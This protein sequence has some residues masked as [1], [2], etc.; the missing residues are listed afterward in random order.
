MGE[1]FLSRM[2]SVVGDIEAVLAL[3]PKVKEH[4]AYVPTRTTKKAR[5]YWKRNENIHGCSK[6]RNFDDIK[7]TSLSERGA[8]RESNRC[9]K[10]VDA[11]CQ[12]SCPTQLDVKSFIGCISNRNFYG[13]AKYIFSD[14]PLGLTCGMVCPTS[15]LCV[16]GCNLYDAEEG[17][18]NIGGLQQFATE[19]FKRMN[20]P[21]IRDP[22][23]PPLSELPD[24]YK[25]KIALIGC[26]PAS[27]SC[28]TFLG[29]LG[30]QDVTIYER[31]DFTGG[32]SSS[33][34]PGF[35]LPFETVKFEIDQM[36]DLGVKVVTGKELGV[37]GFSIQSL[38]A[39]GN[40]AIFLGIGLG[41]PR[42]T[43]IFDGLTEESG[44]YTSKSFL[45]AVSKASKPGMCSCKTQLPQLH[46][47]V[48]VLGAGDTA[49][50][51]ATSAFRCGAKRV[52]VA[53]RRAFRHMRAVPEEV[54]IAKDEACDF[55]PY[56][57]PSNVTVNEKG[58]IS[59][60]TFERFEEQDDGSYKLDKE[61]TTKIR[62]D[63]VISAFGSTTQPHVVE[64]CSPL[65]I[66][67][68]SI[69]V[70][71]VTGATEVDWIFA[72][73]DIVGNGTTVE[74]V[75]DGKQAAWWVHKY[76][77]QTHGLM[78][79]PTPQLPNFFTP[80]DQVDISIDVGPLHFENPF[81][82]ASATPCTSAGM[83]DRAFD[84]GWGFAV[85]NVSPR[86]IRG[87]TT[88]HLFGPGQ[89]SFMNIELI[90]EKT[91]EY[92]CSHV[93]ALKKKHPKKIIISSIMCSYSK[94]DWQE[95]TKIA[96]AAGPDALELNLSCP[97]GMGER[98]MGLACGQDP[99][100][101]RD[102]CKW[103]RE[104]SPIPFFAKLTPNV[105]DV[106]VIAQA[107]KEGGADGVTAVNTVSTLQ[108]IK[109][110]SEA[111]PAVGNEK[112]TTYGG[113]SG[114]AVRPI[115]LKA[116][117]SIA[118][119]LP[120]FP[121]LATG[122][123]DSA[124]ATLQF[125]HAGASTVQICSAVHNKEFTVVQDY[126]Y[127]LKC[128]LYL[129]AK[130]TKNWDGQSAPRVKRLEELLKDGQHLPRFG[131]FKQ[132]RAAIRKE[133]AEANDVLEV[134]EKQTPSRLERELTSEIPSIAGQLGRAL[135]R[136]GNY[137]DLNNKEQVVALVDEDLCVNCGKC[138]MTCNDS[139]YQA[140]LFD[141][142]THYPTV[143][144]DCTGCTLC[145]SVCPIPD[146]ITMVPR[147]TPYAP[148]RGTPVPEDYYTAK[149]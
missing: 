118:N 49:F 76:I 43:P 85:T 51:C 72:G 40:V 28:G 71:D 73:G 47:H 21:Q 63:F 6:N 128:N 129:M 29:R 104:V 137:G 88:G 54:D 103:V 120:G 39:D 132:Q 125:I 127:G 30:Y 2:V 35:R 79:P 98:G 57:S 109:P 36:R 105:T 58:H 147:E 146:C 24:S 62:A 106:R 15:D 27:I 140:I 135:D 117:A 13:A 145:L 81:G 46:G 95:L 114:N 33:E 12:K 50:D 102:I 67:G 134:N 5:E 53:F 113:M 61:Q 133:Y 70:D 91:A 9:L 89:S 74:A 52:T 31:E 80:V 77:Q 94:E 148:I 25:Q 8:L 126:I 101:V 138:Y 149:A 23:L 130:D 90:S 56:A 110:D 41:A 14:N 65:K 18:I 66:E 97:H 84:A 34:I 99:V 42:V 60:V 4:A 26:G 68:G 141:P 75:N 139:G 38:K 121:I 19:N 93:K 7:P 143:T 11:P 124:D 131:Q 108:T 17:P 48:I 96:V 55:L 16:G 82:L 22:S 37:D 107:A 87:S 64:A 100:L 123:I 115:A 20:I 122:G 119:H 1:H 10:C 136:I 112:R 59:Y 86:I 111:W 44:F 83:I 32:L 142:E 144:D 45:P 116:V 69:K 3:H 92:W 78:V